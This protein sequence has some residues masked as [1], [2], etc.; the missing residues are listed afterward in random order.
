M[1]ILMVKHFLHDH[2]FSEGKKLKQ[3]NIINRKCFIMVFPFKM[4][5]QQHI[6]VGFSVLTKSFMDS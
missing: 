3:E 4:F 2:K 5:V 6:I 1:Q